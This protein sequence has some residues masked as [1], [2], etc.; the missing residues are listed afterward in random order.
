VGAA[1]LAHEASVPVGLEPVAVAARSDDEVWVVNHG[2]GRA[3]VWVFDAGDPGPFGGVPLRIVP[4]FSDTPRA[5][6]SAPTSG[7][8]TQ[9]P[10]RRGTG[11]PP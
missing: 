7:R 1:G 4:L 5:L 8:S 2:V 6:R 11:P 3:D 9:R 10:S